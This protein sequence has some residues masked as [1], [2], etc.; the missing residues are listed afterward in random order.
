MARFEVF[1]YRIPID[2]Q[3]DDLNR[4]LASN[5]VANVNQYLVETGGGAMLMFVVEVVRADTSHEKRPSG[6]RI[7]YKEILS[8]SDFAIY[9]QLRSLR[10]ELAEAGGLPLFAVLS[11]AQLAAMAQQRPASETELQAIEGL[12]KRRTQKYS[13]AFLKKIAECVSQDNTDQ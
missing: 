11:N 5:R 2:G 1:Q 7:D 6:Q 8:P 9:S 12:G 13:E 4:C 3:L 10:K